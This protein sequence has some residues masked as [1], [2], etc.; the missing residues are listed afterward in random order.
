MAD[1]GLFMIRGD[2]VALALY[3]KEELVKLFKFTT[4]QQEQMYKKLGKSNLLV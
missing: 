3:K 4:R 1:I 2:L